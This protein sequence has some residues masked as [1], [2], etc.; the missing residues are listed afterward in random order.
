MYRFVR[1]LLKQFIVIT[2]EVL[3]L[4]TDLSEVEGDGISDEFEG[5]LSIPSPNS[6]NENEGSTDT[7]LVDTSIIDADVVDTNIIE[8]NNL[9]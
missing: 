8:A 2:E 9:E 7:E 1:C 6:D 5:E 4:I 3:K